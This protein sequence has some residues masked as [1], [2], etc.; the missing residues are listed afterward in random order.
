MADRDVG[1]MGEH[2]FASWCASVG[3]I[4]NRPERDA[5]GWDY[6]VQF[7]APEVPPGVCTL[8]HIEPPRSC[9]IQVKSTD[10]KTASNIALS[11]WLRMIDPAL[12]FFVLLLD[13][14]GQEHA[15]EA[16]LVHVDQR[17]IEKVLKRLR[18][19]GAADIQSLHKQ[20]MVVPWDDADRLP[21][22][23]GSAL[24]TRLKQQLGPS[25]REY[26]TEKT[27]W[28]ADAGYGQARFSIAFTTTAPS[29]ESAEDLLI[30]FALGLS[31]EL[32]CTVTAIEEVRFG[33]AAPADDGPFPRDVSI[34][35]PELPS[36]PG[37]LDLSDES[38][39]NRVSHPVRFFHPRMVFPFLQTDRLRFRIAMANVD[40]V[41]GNP[42]TSPQFHVA[43]MQ[44]STE[45]RPLAEWARTVRALKFLTEPGQTVIMALNVLGVQARWRLSGVKCSTIPAFDLEVMQSVLDAASA[46][47]VLKIEIDEPVSLLEL[48][49]RRRRLAD[50]ALV[51]R[52]SASDVVLRGDIEE[53][54]PGELVVGNPLVLTIPIGRILVV[55]GMAHIGP[56][57]ECQLRDARW[58]FCVRNP[59]R[60][61]VF[62]EK[63]PMVDGQTYPA[64]PWV[65]KVAARI[66]AQ[67][68]D[69]LP[70]PVLP[71][72]E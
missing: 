10:S 58:E 14:A 43:P 5:G 64:Y 2:E 72:D 71:D 12:P 48:H 37:T 45:R 7:G 35:L 41:L 21:S 44:A 63:I 6:F 42:N 9:W 38:G 1:T 34:A 20:T 66:A 22:P 36:I 59:R 24:L 61:I 57:Q 40:I 29:A 65:Q 54:P 25:A 3:L 8:D 67:N 52:S 69:L 46:L 55:V 16:N 60:E 28:Y 27:R 32:P 23:N 13:F 18:E 49:H 50:A 62:V 30:D 11:N 39:L 26:H 53:P 56:I 15:V 31:K 68:I 17:F 4:P 51:L 47:D 19:L 70:A 33:I